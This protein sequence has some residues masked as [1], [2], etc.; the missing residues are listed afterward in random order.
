[1][2]MPLPVNV[3]ESMTGVLATA[4]SSPLNGP[5]GGLWTLGFDP[6]VLVSPWK[7]LVYLATLCAWAW[8]VTT[9]LDKHAGRFFLPRQ[10][11]NLFHLCVG[12]VALLLAFFLPVGGIVGFLA[13]WGGMVFLLA[14]S[15]LVYQVA[16]SRDE[17][18]PEK[19][20]VGF[21]G[22]TGGLD[23]EGRKAKEAK[24][25]AVQ[26]GKVKFTIKG[27]DKAE[28][29]APAPDSPELAVR[30]MAE[31]LYLKALEA[32]STQLEIGPGGGNQY[33][34]M[35]LVDGVKLA[36]EPMAPQDAVKVMD[37]W[38]SAA[39]LD[40]ADR[41][42]RLTGNVTTE[43]AGGQERKLV[44]VTSQGVQGGMRLSLLFDPEAAVRRKA[45]DMG[46]LDEQLKFM[47]ELTTGNRGLVLLAGLPDGGRTTLLYSVVGMHDAY[48]QTV[49]TVEMEPQLAL[50]GVRHQAFDPTVEGADYATLV[51]SMLRRDPNV[52]G[53]AEIPDANTA[54]ELARADFNRTRVYALV[55]AGSVMEAV[56][57]WIKAVGE[58]ELATKNLQAVVS[59]RLMR[60][61]C[62]QCRVPYP[63]SPDLLRKLG[64]SEAKGE[65]QLFKKGGQIMVK[66]RPE[67]CPVCKGSGYFDQTGVFEVTM[68]GEEERE[69]LASGNLAGFRAVLKKNGVVMIQQAAIRKAL[70]GVTSVEEVMRITT[71]GATPAAQGAAKA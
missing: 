50:E 16:T 43:R 60:K 44:R 63:A 7:P 55:R 62:T 4:L 39:K 56:E 19:F 10:N 3:A 35:M 6:N 34:P 41:R 8:V 21:L 15:L 68:I 26:V 23:K 51:R 40:V 29:P 42:R 38:K 25:P 59:H 5:L 28:V 54:K 12:L 70:S 57:G 46:L 11:W 61:L 2:T 58:A 22:I 20:R 24:G 37:F 65:Q 30:A 18:V 45:Q 71:G 66:N 13:G 31:D 53:V 64:V 48:T 69:A 17:R 14:M 33:Q 9:R 49:Q 36:G 27:P 52:L 67:T 32:R 1:M 47:Q